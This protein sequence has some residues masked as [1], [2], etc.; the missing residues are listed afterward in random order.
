MHHAADGAPDHP[1]GQPSNDL[2][3]PTGNTVVLRLESGTYLII[4]HL[5]ILLAGAV[6]QHAGAGR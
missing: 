1:P 2:E 6:V 5:N 3:N 4:A